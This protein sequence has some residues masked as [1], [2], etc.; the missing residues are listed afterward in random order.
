M[1][2]YPLV[3]THIAMESMESEPCFVS[4]PIKHG[5]FHEFSIAMLNYQRVK[6]W[7][8]VYLKPSA[9]DIM[10]GHH[11]LESLEAGACIEQ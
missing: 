8:G 7:E 1:G 4:F 5:E 6:E 2:R 9:L 10:Y 11:V 3:M